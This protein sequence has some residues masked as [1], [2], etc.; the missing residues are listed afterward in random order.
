MSG[1]GVR[2]ETVRQRLWQKEWDH[3]R[4]L[5]QHLLGER[6]FPIRVNLRPPSGRQALDDMAAFHAFIEAWRSWPSPSQLEWRRI[7]YAQLGEQEVPAA[8]VIGSF[9]E[10]V[11]CLGDSAKKRSRQWQ[12]RMDPI[13]AVSQR[14]YPALVDQLNS[15]ERLSAAEAETMA[16]LLPQLARGMGRGCYLR[17]LPVTG[18]DTKFIES[19]QPLISRL[20]D[21]LHGGELSRSGGL[22]SWLGCVA[23]PADWLWV[24]PLCVVTR[25]ALGGLPVLRLPTAVLKAVPLPG[26]RVLVVENEQPGYALP[27][28]ADTVAVFGGGRNLAWME[29]GWLRHRVIG[30]WGDLDSWG[31]LF[32]SEA[33]QR[34]PHLASVLM[35]RE[36]LRLH[37]DRMVAEPEP[38]PGLPAHLT[39][40]ECRLYLELRDGIHGNTRLEQE[41]IS[42]DHIRMCLG[43]WLRQ[44]A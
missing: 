21:A 9:Q 17:A 28:L 23:T 42:A 20:L 37:R 6:A 11:E 27:E 14:L 25:Q 3:P 18:V 40:P 31:L 19:N 26:A 5:R 29:A 12:R 15:V 35:D 41:R 7:R 38:Y 1:W 16:R 39:E 22:L 2:P 33:R 43:R 36:T 10:L 8:V 4:H 32:F 13:L 34:Q 24:R 44:Q 30:Y